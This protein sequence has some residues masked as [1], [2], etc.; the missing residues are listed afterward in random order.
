M[1]EIRVEWKVNDT[2]GRKWGRMS[3][4][5]YNGQRVLDDAGNREGEEDRQVVGWG[6]DRNRK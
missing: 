1:G 5:G 2:G 4:W 3:G 6:D